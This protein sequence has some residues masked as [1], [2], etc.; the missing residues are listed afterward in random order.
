MLITYFEEDIL[1]SIEELDSTGQNNLFGVKYY[2]ENGQ[3][4]GH[5][6]YEGK[7]KIFLEWYENGQMSVK[8]IEDLE[9]NLIEL[10]EWDENG[11]IINQE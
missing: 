6:Y 7:T 3:M 4:E 9:G 8:R 1:T 5:Q 11:K 10:T 2:Y